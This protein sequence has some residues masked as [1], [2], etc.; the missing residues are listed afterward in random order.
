L[1]L[2]N[3]SAIRFLL[4]YDVFISKK[5]GEREGSCLL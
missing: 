1:A 5:V 2:Y 4:D 3:G